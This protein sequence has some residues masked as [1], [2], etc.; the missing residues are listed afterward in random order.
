[1]SLRERVELTSMETGKIVIRVYYFDLLSTNTN[2]RKR[3]HCGGRKTLSSSWN[4]KAR[5][6]ARQKEPCQPKNPQIATRFP[7]DLL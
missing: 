6:I 5:S 1:M 4:N 7:S 3:N 2:G